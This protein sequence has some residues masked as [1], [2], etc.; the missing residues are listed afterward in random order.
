MKNGGEND[1]T[2]LNE[3]ITKCHIFLFS[4]G[5]KPNLIILLWSFKFQSAV[6]VIKL[7]SCYYQINPV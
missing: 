6:F 2:I 1:E 4:F 3:N 5:I 7:K